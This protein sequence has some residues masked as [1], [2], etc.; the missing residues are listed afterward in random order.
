[1]LGRGIRVLLLLAAPCLCAGAEDLRA[2]PR[3]PQPVAID[4]E[5]DVLEWSVAAAQPLP[6]E[7]D[8]QRVVPTSW[9]TTVRLAHDGRNLLVAF[10]AQDADPGRIVAARGARDTIGNEDYVVVQIDAEGSRQR[11]YEFRVNAAGVLDD[12]IVGG[13]SAGSPQWSGAWVAAARRSDNGYVVEMSIPLSTLN[14]RMAADGSLA[15]P[16]NVT[17]HIGRDRRETLSLLPVD[18]TELCQECQY[19][20]FPLPDVQGER[21]GLQLRPYLA[22]RRANQYPQGAAATSD[23]SID[24]GMDVLWRLGGGRKVV[25]TVNPDFS[26]VAPDQIQFD[27]NRR[28]AVSF[29]ENRPFFTENAGAFG[30]LIPL[31][32]TRSIADPK[33]AIA[34]SAQTPKTTATALYSLDRATSFIVPSQTGSRLVAIDDDS[35]TFL[36]RLQANGASGRRAG[37][38]LTGRRATDYD[39]VVAAVDG[40]LPFGER[41]AVQALAA[42]SRAHAGGEVASDFGLPGQAEGSAVKVDYNYRQERYGSNTNA[43][44]STKGF[45][46]DAGNLGR[47]GNTSVFHE[48][49]WNIPRPAGGRN[50]NF[51]GGLWGSLLDLTD[52]HDGEWNV[53]AWGYMNFSDGSGM[54]GY[55]HYTDEIYQGRT[56]H[57]LDVGTSWGWQINPQVRVF[58]GINRREEIDLQA[59]ESAVSIRPFFGF[60]LKVGA[61]LSMSGN[62]EFDNTDGEATR[63]YRTGFA[64][65]R[66]NWSPRLGHTLSLVSNWGGTHEVHKLTME[67][68]TRSDR[69]VAQLVYLYQRADR[70]SFQI[71]VNAGGVGDDGMSSIH[72]SSQLVFS[73]LILNLDFG[74]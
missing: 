31:V 16:M 73:K 41:H 26:E 53:E 37:L 11:H 71:G 28:F 47:V 38:L 45:R 30:A 22:V 27:V 24:P 2:I 9:Q 6:S 64:L 68:D 65:L 18:T 17:R 35:A 44:Y 19:A 15:M 14:V 21:Q 50:S 3:N 51:G 4:G 60:N 1:V 25:A 42:V 74:G 58:A 55:V 20:L 36:G 59:V 5:I 12:R 10:D 46:A 33:A 48:W 63:N 49:Y 69:A 39:N 34:Y 29:A 72:K 52:E 61:T 67:P 7:I 8:P 32:Y 40:R 43:V 70:S 54:D 57:D 23:T 62:Y 66:A 13:S 56:F